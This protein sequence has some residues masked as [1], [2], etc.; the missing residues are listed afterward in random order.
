MII[1]IETVVFCFQK[2]IGIGQLANI[3]CIPVPSE[4]LLGL[5]EGVEKYERA[6]CILYYGVSIS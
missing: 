2:H 4:G 1:Y 3:H 6:V 5:G